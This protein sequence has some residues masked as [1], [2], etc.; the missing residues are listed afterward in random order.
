MENNVKKY[1]Y[2]NDTYN[3]Y[4]NITYNTY[5]IYNIYIIL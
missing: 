5:N 2:K 4:Y 1:I 3:I